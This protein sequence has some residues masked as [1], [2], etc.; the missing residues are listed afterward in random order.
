MP[1][2]ACATPPARRQPLGQRASRRTHA[3]A[4]Q[5]PAAAG[6]RPRELGPEEVRGDGAHRGIAR[7]AVAAVGPGAAGEHPVGGG[8]VVAVAMGEAADH[9]A[10][11]HPLGVLRE[12]L[13]DLD[14][15]EVRADRLEGPAELGR[16]FGIHVEGVELRPPAVHPDEDHALA[17][18]G[19]GS[20]QE[21]VPAGPAR[22]DFHRTLPRVHSTCPR[23]WARR[24]EWDRSQS[25]SLRSRPAFSPRRMPRPR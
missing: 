6:E 24:P 12:E 8:P 18:A 19:P 7:L 13:A 22:S 21:S 23:A 17:R 5:G 14:A 25:H 20:C 4:D 16:A 9:R 1:G 2:S 15:G 3:G 10:R 11:V